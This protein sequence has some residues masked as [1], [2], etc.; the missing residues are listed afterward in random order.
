MLP[1]L[2]RWMLLLSFLVALG[3]GA[4]PVPV[5]SAA[6]R[7]FAVAVA[8]PDTQRPALLA[9]SADDTGYAFRRRIADA[10]PFFLK[11]AALGTYLLYDDGG[12]YLVSDGA[13]LQRETQ[14]L[15]DVLTVDDDFQSPAEWD[16]EAVDGRRAGLR[17]RHRRSGRYLA[18]GGLVERRRHAA[19]VR[20]IPRQGCAGFPEAS[21]DALGRVRRVEFEDGAVFGVVD[22]HS[23]L[24]SNFGFGGGGLFHGSPFH[25][26]GVEHALPDC[27]VY[28]GD[29]GRRDVFG[30]GFD[31]PDDSAGLL[32]A[33]A[34]GQTPTANHATAGWPA[35]TDWPSAPTSSTHQVQYYKWLER[36]YLGGLRLVVQH[37]TTNQIICDVV[38]GAG[39]QA[40]RYACNDMVAVDRILDET[41]AMEAYIDAQEGGPGRGWFRIVT[42]PEE[43]RR[44]IRSGK[45]AVVLGIETSNL[46][47]CLLVPTQE[48]PACTEQTVREK[49]DA[50]HARGVRAIFPVHKYDNA[51]S[52]GDGHKGIIELGNFIQTGH[53]SNLVSYCDPGV[54]G[55]FDR[56][57]AAFPGLIEP[58][59]DFFAPPPNDLS[60]LAD[61]PLGTL[62]PFLPRLLAPPTGEEVCQATGLTPLGEFLI[63]EMM[64]RGMIVEVDH[65]PRLAY[66]RAYELLAEHDY[67]ASGSHH[68][69][70][71]G[72]LY[73]LGGVSATSLGT[74]QTPGVRSTM[75]DALQSR[76]AQIEQAGGYPAEGFAFDLNGFAG[77]R[78]PR[79]GPDSACPAPQRRPVRYPFPSYAGDVLFTQP[80]VGERVLD[81]NTEGLVHIG[82]LPE[83]IEDARRDGVSDAE[84]APLFKSAEGHL[85]MWEKAERRGR[86]LR[87]FGR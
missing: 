25:R 1:H 63:E 61:D 29:E 59:A 58:R 87:T 49:L 30:Y 35:F 38:K 72:E 66:R 4:E 80:Q 46:F 2:L 82:L 54:A 55:G 16:L 76:V 15:S 27:S 47:D 68:R 74:C 24:L 23:H 13:T 9:R 32:L 12:A 78:G 52:A 6:N 8:D 53:F 81:F 75:D 14:L 69:N 37:A 79:F 26:L 86:A 20:L 71:F 19:H 73:R 43:A 67:P 51:F 18:T 28:H 50:Y 64:R 62:T 31:N 11:P 60:G 77:A 65:L 84:L 17:L 22:S 41:R 10:T 40:T 21:L 36:A 45:L 57:P 7:C 70:H 48:F 5:H 83:M 56:G 3:A 44:V 85:R 39:I 42:S 33:L 34:T